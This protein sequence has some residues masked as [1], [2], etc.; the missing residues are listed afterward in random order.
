MKKLNN[1]SEVD[2]EALRK[3]PIKLAFLSPGDASFMKAIRMACERNLI[4]PVLIGK[5]DLMQAAAAE[6]DF[7]ISSFSQI[8]I[9]NPQ[10]I[11]DKGVDMLS[12]GEVDSISKGQMSTNYVYRA[13]IRKMKKTGGEQMIAVTSFWEISPLGH[14]VILTD[15]G[16]NITPDRETKV[17]LV[18]KAIAYLGLF[19][20][21]DP[22]IMTVSAKRELNRELSSHTD[23]QYIEEALAGEGYKCPVRSGNIKNL[24]EAEPDE[25]PNILLMPHLVTGNS[26]VKLDFFLDVKRRG[27]IMTSWGPVLIPA[28]ADSASHLVDEISLAVVAAS[29]F[30]EG[31]RENFC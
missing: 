26:I 17:K 12:A 23:A 18:K 13:V 5:K 15:P 21:D 25:R 8:F 16:V 4:V 20:H 7:D 29:R 22:K 19:G 1:V 10:L 11:A 9:D 30:K 28:R 6:I 3:G 31:Y 24:F 27:V 2:A 14:F